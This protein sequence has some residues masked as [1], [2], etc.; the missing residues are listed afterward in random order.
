MPRI[1]STGRY[2]PTFSLSRQ[3]GAGV[4]EIPDAHR[5]DALPKR[6]P[7]PKAGAV[8]RAMDLGIIGG[9]RCRGIIGSIIM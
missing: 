9:G 2:S 1:V 5:W 8:E 7:A 6:T 4:G 3:G